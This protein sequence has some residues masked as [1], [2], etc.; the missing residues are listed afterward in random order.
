MAAPGND[1][2]LVTTRIA[3][4]IVV[5][6][7]LGALGL[8]YYERR[9][10]PADD[11]PLTK[12]PE[13]IGSW[14]VVAEEVRVEPDG[15][16]QLLERTYRNPDGVEAELRM[17]ATYTR[18]GSLRDW[19]LASM[20]SGW[21]PTEERIWESSDGTMRARIQL[22]VNGENKLV[23]LT[24]YTSARSQA[25][26]LADAEL[27]AW[28]DRLLGDLRPWA[29][30]YLL[31]GAQQQEEAERI[32]TELA[33]SLG[34][35]IRQLMTQQPRNHGQGILSTNE[36]PAQFIPFEP[37]CEAA[38]WNAAMMQRGVHS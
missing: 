30:L 16:Y 11:I 23:A 17:Q 19:S 9:V 36:S 24:W 3:K 25:P 28:R 35:R 22:L 15:S 34:P 38:A 29:S 18:L 33:S 20:A 4:V 10:V 7:L 14:R 1:N 8:G 13:E 2:R 32:V 6:L 12:L 31:A 27:Q 37:R 21:T 5:A 26:T